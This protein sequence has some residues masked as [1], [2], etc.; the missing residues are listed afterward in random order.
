M[1]DGSPGPYPRDRTNPIK[2]LYTPFDCPS[3]PPSFSSPTSDCPHLDVRPSRRNGPTHRHPS[4]GRERHKVRETDT[5]PKLRDR[6]CINYY[7]SDTNKRHHSHSPPFSVPTPRNSCVCDSDIV[8]PG[9]GKEYRPG[10]GRTKEGR[11]RSPTSS[12]LSGT[13]RTVSLRSRTSCTNPRCHS[14]L[15]LVARP[16]ERGEEGEGYD[17]STDDGS[18]R[19]EGGNGDQTGRGR[20]RVPG[21]HR[22]TTGTV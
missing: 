21:S 14:S 4:N 10:L 3:I 20:G 19:P 7:K 8:L 11:S 1:K 5:C 15:V 16:L 18:Q 17:G 12:T 13:S 9:L 6:P 22:G 2:V